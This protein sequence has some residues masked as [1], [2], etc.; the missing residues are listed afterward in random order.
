MDQWKM[1]INCENVLRKHVQYAQQKK[2]LTWGKESR[3]DWFYKIKERISDIRN[4]SEILLKWSDWIK[5]IFHNTRKKSTLENIEESEIQKQEERSAV[6][7]WKR[8]IF[9]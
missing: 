9:F 1:R 4:R 2:K 6:D 7:M 5:E 8:I 3:S